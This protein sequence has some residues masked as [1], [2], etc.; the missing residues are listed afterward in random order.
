MTPI[1]LH[2]QLVIPN[3]RESITEMPFLVSV[4]DSIEST[5][6]KQPKG[7]GPM[8]ILGIVGVV[9]AGCA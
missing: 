8:G 3:G 5:L 7:T 2:S 6:S 4:T 1:S 9:L